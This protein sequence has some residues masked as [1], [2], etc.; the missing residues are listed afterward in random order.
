MAE[1]K[2]QI[3]IGVV[4]ALV[5]AVGVVFVAVTVFPTHPGILVPILVGL[6]AKQVTCSLSTG[7]CSMVIVNNSTVPVSLDS[8]L[9]TFISGLN[10]TTPIYSSSNGIVG[11]QAALTGVPAH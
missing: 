7:I 11:G 10:Y 4:L 8:C 1:F 6:N 3:G 5:V 2:K 9:M